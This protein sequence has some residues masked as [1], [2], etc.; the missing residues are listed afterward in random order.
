M[1]VELD[2][3][4]DAR[5]VVMAYALAGRYPDAARAVLFYGSCLREAQLDGLMLDF[6]LIVS[7]YEAAYGKGWLAR[8]NRW[9]PPNVFPFEHDGLAAKYAVL[10]E[11]DFARLCGEQA[12]NVSVWA[13]F[14]QPSRLLWCADTEAR[15]TAIAAIAQAAPTLLRLAQPTADRSDAL[16]LWQHGFSLTYGAE[17]RAERSGRSGSIVDSDP[18]RFRRFYDA[19]VAGGQLDPAGRFDAA[20]REANMRRWRRLQRRGKWLTVARLA[21]ASFTFAGGIDYLAWK[22]NR[23]AGTRIM[24]RPW[25]RRWP[26][27]GALTLLPRLFA[28]R[29]IR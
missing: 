17:I 22:I 6:Y 9:I 2:T 7:D 18:A 5:A 27:L 16:T 15:R 19:A 1:A 24:I 25:Q 11:A 12:D 3:P 8:A 29:A 26:L 14:A 20:E 28:S 21:K 10:S 4:S 23:H 13:R